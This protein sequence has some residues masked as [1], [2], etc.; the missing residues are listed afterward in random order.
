[1][2]K[3]NFFASAF[4][5]ALLLA[6][7]AP[8]GARAQDTTSVAGRDEGGDIVVKVGDSPVAFDTAKP[9][10]IGGR[11]MVPV[12]GVFEK[13]GG[14]VQWDPS[15]QTVKGARQGG[16]NRF[17]MQ[18]DKTEAMVDDKTTT[19]D[20]PPRLE[21]GATYVP[22]RF[23][24]E[25][26]G[27]TV[28][29][30]SATH[31]V[32]IKPSENA[33]PQAAPTA[34]GDQANAPSETITP[35]S[36]GDT[37]S[38]ATANPPGPAGAATGTTTAPPPAATITPAAPP[39]SAPD[40]N[41]ASDDAAATNDGGFLRYLPWILGGLALAALAAF[42]LTRKPAGQVIAASKGGETTTTARRDDNK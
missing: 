11:V 2:N 19:L 38:A 3:R 5:T 35:S 20:T 40:V 17:Q 7:L 26:L 37:S 10:M 31:T 34:A 22:L 42:L 21:A 12:R 8:G 4:G 13:L 16:D 27:A 28:N 14:T 23:V 6:V 29:Y 24:S 41:P 32:S 25:A 36:T 1:M 33:S 9:R 15:T 39:R 30:D 18:I